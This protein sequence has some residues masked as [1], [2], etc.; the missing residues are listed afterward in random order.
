[1]LSNERQLHTKRI[2]TTVSSMLR[3]RDRFVGN[4]RADNRV[5][6][7]WKIS[8]EGAENVSLAAAPHGCAEDGEQKVRARRH[9]P[10]TLDQL[11][12]II[13]GNQGRTWRISIETVPLHAEQ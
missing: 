5:V 12:I 7:C 1:M 6:D 11:T 2:D 10:S 9:T 3:D 13:H 4:G 8:L